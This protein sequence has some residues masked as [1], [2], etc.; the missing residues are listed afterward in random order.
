MGWGILLLD[1]DRY[2]G[3]FTLRNMSLHHFWPVLILLMASCV[4]V[5]SSH[6]IPGFLLFPPSRLLCLMRACNHTRSFGYWSRRWKTVEDGV[7]YWAVCHFW[8]VSFFSRS[9]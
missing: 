3:G 5:G 7:Y 2:L 4:G 1:T 6:D 8:R 9:W